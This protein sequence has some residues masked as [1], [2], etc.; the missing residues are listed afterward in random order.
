M[1]DEWSIEQGKCIR[2]GACVIF[3]PEIFAIGTKG[4][5]RVIRAP[6]TPL[7]ERRARGAM[8]NCPTNAVQSLVH[9]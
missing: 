5:A 3:A 2:C 1:S 6:A 9:A 8:L 4:S 7:E